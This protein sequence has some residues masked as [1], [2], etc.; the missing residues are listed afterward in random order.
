MSARGRLPEALPT[1]VLLVEDS[2]GDVRLM[3]EALKEA[4]AQI[5]LN[6]VS[7]G[8]EAM[9]FLRLEGMYANAPRPD[10]ILLDLNLP[11]IDGRRVLGL[12]KGDESLKTIPT[13]ILTTSQS[14]AD[15]TM[16]YQLQANCFLNKPVQLAEFYSLVSSISD[17]WLGKVSLPQWRRQQ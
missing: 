2:G 17:F 14:E 16:C 9:E 11:K 10:L 13:L 8:V 7:D 1:S 3:R 4:N 6:V 15:I 12:I 5:L